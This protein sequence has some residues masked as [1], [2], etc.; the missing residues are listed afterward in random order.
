MRRLSRPIAIILAIAGC[1]ALTPVLLAGDINPPAGPVQ[2]TGRITINPQTATFPITITQPGSYVVLGDLNAPANVN[3][4]VIN[5]SD[6]TLDL[7]GFTLNGGGSAFEGIIVGQGMLVENVEIRNGSIKGFQNGGVYG[8]SAQYM[9]VEDVRSSGNG[10]EGIRPG[11]FGLVRDCVVRGNAIGIYAGTGTKVMDCLV[12]GNSTGINALTGVSVSGCSVSQNTA[13]GI[14]VGGE[15][16]IRDNHVTSLGTPGGTGIFQRNELT[17]RSRI[18]SN[19]IVGYNP[20][21]ETAA[22]LS[23]GEVLIVRN[24][25]LDAGGSSGYVQGGN[26]INVG[27]SFD[28]DTADAWDNFWWVTIIRSTD[29]DDAAAP[30]RDDPTPDP[31]RD[32]NR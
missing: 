22:T 27:L 26:M 8:A 19:H 1:G 18:D 11:G 9:V 4:I 20:G 24:S 7:N 5:A 13:I 2:E 10:F 16:D 28:P 17:G 6:V 3:G 23:L 32:R 31:R 12:I 25:V 14:S 30:S 29:G 21:I 15:C